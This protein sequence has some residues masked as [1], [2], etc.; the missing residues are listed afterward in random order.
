MLSIVRILEFPHYFCNKVLLDAFS[1]HTYRGYKVA[2][3]SHDQ[4]N[5]ARVQNSRIERSDLLCG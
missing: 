2:L 1:H 5:Y 4:Q 3:E